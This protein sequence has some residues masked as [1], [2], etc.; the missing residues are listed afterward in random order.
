MI[1]PRPLW[2]AAAIP[3]RPRINAPVGAGDNDHHKVEGCFKAFG[4]ALRMGLA[5]EGRGDALPS[6]KGVL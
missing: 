2:C 6:T 1:E 4:R 5:I 3:A